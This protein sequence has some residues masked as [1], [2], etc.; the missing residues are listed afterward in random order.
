MFCRFCGAQIDQDSVFCDKC[1]KRQVNISDS[2]INKSSGNSKIKYGVIIAAVVIIVLILSV[3]VIKK[4]SS[5][6]SSFVSSEENDN[7][8]LDYDNI[9]TP[10]NIGDANTEYTKQV[11]NTNKASD[12]APKDLVNE[13]EATSSSI[14]DI[15]S[16]YNPND[17]IKNAKITDNITQ[18]FDETFYGGEITF[19]E[20]R[21]II[22]HKFDDQPV[23]KY[24]DKIYGD[25]N[26]EGEY[27]NENLIYLYCTF[28]DDVDS[29]TLQAIFYQDPEK[30]KNGAEYLDDYLFSA[31]WPPQVL[32]ERT[33]PELYSEGDQYE[34]Y[35]VWTPLLYYL[36]FGDYASL[37]I[38][39][40]KEDL[41]KN[42]AICEHKGY[43]YNEYLSEVSFYENYP[44]YGWVIRVRSGGFD[45]SIITSFN[46]MDDI[47][48]MV[49]A[50]I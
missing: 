18:V 11:D 35:K 44:Y 39:Q 27:S 30:V 1:G 3:I 7:Q 42:G 15:F 38:E 25:H 29:V 48:E 28:E 37:T 6:V 31:I 47:L 16:Q 10:G 5:T 32:G 14:R 2:V 33:V 12:D 21:N 8:A 40:V 19:K 9:E 46:K 24:S 13:K 22:S 41:L 36:R 20:F 43:S 45:Y 23:I 34:L 50:N 26:G 17:Q 4:I 49:Y